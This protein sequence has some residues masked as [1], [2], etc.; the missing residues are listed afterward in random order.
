MGR[1]GRCGDDWWGK[2]LNGGDWFGEAVKGKVRLG[3]VGSDAVC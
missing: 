1:H 2:V 3:A